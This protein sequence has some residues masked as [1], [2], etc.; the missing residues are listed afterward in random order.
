MSFLRIFALL[1]VVSGCSTLL[2]Q[3]QPTPEE[4]AFIYELNRARQNPQRYETENGLTAGLLAAATQQ[5]PLALNLSLV[6]SARWHSQDMATNAYFAHTRPAGLGGQEPNWMAR[7]KWKGS[8]PPSAYPLY[9]SWPD[10]ANYIESLAALYSTTAISYAPTDALR[11][12]IV[13]AG[14][15]PPRAPYPLAGHE[16]VLRATPRNRHRLRGRARRIGMEQRRVLVDPHR[17]S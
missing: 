10:A 16:R 4:V 2:A 8:S 17:A 14:V 5:P 7:H 6:E 9:S 12:L 1:L 13:D 3:Q 11:A 15:T